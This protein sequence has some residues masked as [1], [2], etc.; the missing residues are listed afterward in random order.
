MEPIENNPFRVLGLPIT[1][2]VREIEKRATELGTY[3]SMG[4]TKSY[5]TDFDGKP[6]DRAIE[7]VTAAKKKIQIEEEK[8]HHS[9]FWFWN[10]NSVDELAL[11]LVR[12]GQEEKACSIWE[13]AV[14]S[15]R[16]VAFI[17]IPEIEDLILASSDWPESD[18][19]DHRIE[20]E[21]NAFVIE[22]KTAGTTVATAPAD[23]EDSDRW[24][25]ECDVEWMAGDDNVAFAIVFGRGKNSYFS[26]DISANGHYRF[27]RTIDWDFEEIIGWT[28]YDDATISGYDLNHI[29]VERDQ[30]NLI[31]R[32]NGFVAGRVQH[33]PWFGN[34]FGFKVS[35]EQTVH[36]TK[37]RLSN[38]KL[39]GSYA[40]GVKVTRTNVSCAK[41]L[42]LL[43]LNRSSPHDILKSHPWERAI[44]LF[45]KFVSSDYFNEYVRVV[46]GERFVLDWNKTVDDH[47][48]RLVENLKVTLN[49]TYGVTTRAFIDSFSVFPDKNFQVVKNLFAAGSIQK[50]ERAISI[51]EAQRKADATKAVASG[52]ALI[53]S[54]EAEISRIAKTLGDSSIE[55]QLASDKVVDELVLSGIA[56]FNAVQDDEPAL[57]LY[58]YATTIAVTPK[59]IERAKEN[60]RTCELSIP[61]KHIHKLIEECRNVRQVFPGDAISTGQKLIAETKAHLNNLEACAGDESDEFKSTAN[62]LT[63]EI[64]QCGIDHFNS[65]KNDEPALQLY[66]YAVALAASPEAEKHANENLL[67]CK[68]W[69]K[70]KAYLLCHFCGK[71][72][73]EKET[74]VSKTMYVETS[75]ERVFNSTSVG[76]SYGDVLIPRCM[77]CKS[78]HGALTQYYTRFFF[79]ILGGMAT[80]SIGAILIYP[81][82]KNALWRSGWALA[83]GGWTF[84]FSTA[85]LIGLIC[86]SLAYLLI[87]RVD[88]E[89]I[90]KE[91]DIEG[92]PEVTK[93]RS[94][95]WTFSKPSA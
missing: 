4:K 8:F 91:N 89:G 14:F 5:D 59:A 22:R 92:F 53:S 42:A 47:N 33:E 17:Q 48:R 93:R 43:H 64:V 39:D 77:N 37:L 55:Y 3:A 62:Y 73:P 40:S 76:Y 65:T 21:G 20:I 6:I 85:I 50:I 63:F 19:D 86:G 90:R 94:Q 41:N 51:A 61:Q 69:I 9:L 24:L 75:R 80:G 79:V 88:T 87:S 28:K 78:L 2:S 30:E 32:I 74:S 18:D 54:I 56:H 38:F 11:D 72:Q 16:D 67:S 1:A 36:F 12:D 29:Q 58:I 95:G 70:N 44:S 84:V 10:H 26:F 52:K 7:K 81:H 15:N 45:E 49:Q 35:G 60:L 34:R 13:K 82:F 27:G 83:L 46:V 25:I 31:F 71:D 23:F 66:Q 57:P 68:E